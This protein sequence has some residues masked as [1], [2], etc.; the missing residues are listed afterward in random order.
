MDAGSFVYDAYGMR[1]AC[2]LGTQPYAPVENA[3]KQYN[4]SFW[5]MKQTSLR[6]KVFRLGNKAHN[7]LTVNS[8][9]HNV[10]GEAKIID[11]MDTDAA[12]GGSLDMTPVF[13]GQLSSAFRKILLIDGDYLSVS[14]SLTALPGTPA[15]I[16]WRMVTDAAATVTPKGILLEQGGRSM[17][18]C[19]APDDPSI[20][21][22]YRIW[23][24]EGTEE[25]DVPN[26]GKCIVGYS[27]SL[28]E[29][30]SCTINVSLR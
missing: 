2:D 26:P 21:V 10:D 6:W 23:P 11:V 16:E 25:W 30:Q 8:L 9:Q 22:E 4:R 29:G 15:D 5:S 18:L 7:T 19:A 27:V 17:L 1:W 12:R 28:P 24:A 13:A 20:G 14:D 3:F